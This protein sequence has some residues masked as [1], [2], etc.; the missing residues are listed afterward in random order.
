MN[1][2]SLI[3]IIAVVLLV[4]C[5]C[6]LDNESYS[7]VPHIEGRDLTVEVGY[8][9]LGNKVKNVCL[10]FYVIDGDGDIGIDESEGYPYVG[11][12][13]FNFFCTFYS[14]D[15]GIPI[16]D[17]LIDDSSK[18]FTIPYI[19]YS[20]LDPTLKASVFINWQMTDQGVVK[21]PYDSIF[22]EF[23]ILDRAFHKS[24]IAFSDT[25]L[26]DVSK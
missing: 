21:L 4:F 6:E 8:D 14:V 12:S 19:E 5:S 10:E 25:V 20:G 2:K 16:E 24:N 17:S 3:Y 11:D 7:T 9:E 13:V 18:C 23:F 22:C 26:Y 15:N 1:I